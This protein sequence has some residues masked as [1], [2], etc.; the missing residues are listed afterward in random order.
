M[1]RPDYWLDRV[2]PPFLELPARRSS[3]TQTQ[4]A[5]GS[6]AMLRARLSGPDFD[7]ADRIVDRSVILELPADGAP[8]GRLGAGL[9]L[10]IDEGVAAVDEPFP[11]TPLFQELKGFDFTPT[12]R[13]RWMWC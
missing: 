8:L 10:N 7:D 9:L 5:D 4:P 11:G 2:S 1:F 13:S 12:G 6:V 3:S